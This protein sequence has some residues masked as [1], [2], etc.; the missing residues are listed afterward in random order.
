MQTP[1]FE[2]NPFFNNHNSTGT[3][4]QSE[5]LYMLTDPDGT[6][7]ADQDGDFI[8]IYGET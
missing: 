2:A 1:F 8:F 7:L 3:G 6:Y 4:S 5:V